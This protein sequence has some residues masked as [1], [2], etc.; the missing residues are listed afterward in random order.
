[1]L[2]SNGGVLKEMSKEIF[3]NA[4]IY[5]DRNHFEEAMCVEDGIIKEVGRTEDLLSRAGAGCR[6]TDCEG[7]TLIPGMN[8]SHLHFMQYGETLNQAFIEDARSVD[9]L[10]DIC[11]KFMAEH[12]DKTRK[13]IHSIG[14]NQDSFEDSSRLPGKEDLD[15]ISLD[16]PVVLERVCGHIAS[17]N[18]C[19][20]EVMGIDPA[21]HDGI[22]RGDM[23][24]TAKETVP[25]FTMDEKRAIMIE[26]MK[27]AAAMGVTSVQSNDIG[28]DFDDDNEAFAMIGDMYDKD[29]AVI[30]YHYQMCFATPEKFEE[31]LTQGEYLNPRYR[32][33]GSM[34]T[35]GPLKLFKDGSL[36]ARTAYMMDSYADDP[37]NI[38][39]PWLSCEDM[40]RYCSIAARYGIQVVTHAIGNRAISETLDSYEKIMPKGSNPLRHGIVHCQ[41]TDRKLTDRIKRDDVL[42]M[43]QPVFID[44]DMHIVEKLCGSSLASTSYAFGSMLRDGVHLSYGTDCPVESCNPF[45]NIYAAVTRKD[46]QGLPE[47]GFY[48]AERV[49]VETA[50]DAYTVES[51]YAQFM[52]KR[53]GR[54]KPGY[55]AD[56]LILDRDI[57]T[58]DPS[59]IKDI[60]P[61]A[62][63][64]KGRRV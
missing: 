46:K 31:F 19:A 62:T 45:E 33:E 8:D 28:A 15:R 30:R 21:G 60:R 43:A 11:R 37:G 17:V 25:D 23:V 10:V 2:F 64:V 34:L 55:Y 32:E 5:V 29:E 53:K 49:D 42:I 58:A 41:I 13:G 51:A 20:L 24:V 18:S 22:M 4:K 12:P 57:F 44:Y 3:T 59:E 56:F 14:W 61:M 54:L 36:G 47:E 63:I 6:I 7:R 40:D 35:L 38:G 26:T 48:P 50:I 9:E 52:E 16:V 1:M 27:K 39:L